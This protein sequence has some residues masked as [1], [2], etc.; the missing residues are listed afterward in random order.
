[1]PPSLQHACMYAQANEVLLIVSQSL[2]LAGNALYA[3][4]AAAQIISAGL[5]LAYTGA[6]GKAVG[7]R[8]Y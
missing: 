3:V 8:F 7:S 1:M 5:G 6:S 4:A 2:F